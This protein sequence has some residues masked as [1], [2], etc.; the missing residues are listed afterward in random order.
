MAVVKITSRIALAVNLLI[1][2]GYSFPTTAILDTRYLKGRLEFPFKRM[3]RFLNRENDEYKKTITVE[4]KSLASSFVI[5]MNTK[6]ENEEVWSFFPLGKLNS[7]DA[8]NEDFRKGENQVCEIKGYQRK[9]FLTVVVSNE[10]YTVE[11]ELMQLLSRIMVQRMILKYKL[12][13]ESLQVEIKTSNDTIIWSKKLEII[14]KDSSLSIT[15]TLVSLLF[16]DEINNDNN[17]VEWVEMVNSEGIAIGSLPRSLMH[18]WNILH[19]G[20]GI[21]TIYPQKNEIYVHR[22]TSFKKI[23]PNLY[24]MFVGGVSTIYETSI[25]TAKREMKEELGLKEPSSLSEPLFQC[26]ICTSYNRCVVTCFSY[27]Y[28]PLKDHIRHQ[29][30]EV[31]WGDFVP[32]SIVRQSAELSIQRNMGKH[33]LFEKGTAEEWDYVPDGLLVWEAWEQWKKEKEQNKTRVNSRQNKL[34]NMLN[35]V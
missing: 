20:A 18:K 9:S 5:S 24:G 10:N 25:D 26:M 16:D 6:K 1:H 3:K 8:L 13:D 34:N 31:A 28:N 2:Y 27:E 22:R 21:M 14:S 29:E 12:K 33:S 35:I 30:E 19:R 11:E 15:Q 17:D 4:E 32:Y 23:F 7:V